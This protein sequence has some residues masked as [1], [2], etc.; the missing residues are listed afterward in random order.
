MFSTSWSGARTAHEGTQGAQPL[1]KRKGPMFDAL[2]DM[3]D[4]ILSDAEVTNMMR[5]VSLRP[6]KKIR[7]DEVWQKVSRQQGHLCVVLSRKVAY[8]MS[9]CRREDVFFLILKP[10]MLRGWKV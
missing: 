8:I 2:A 10:S 4:D 3:K 7:L 9:Q 5:Q 6:V 1:H